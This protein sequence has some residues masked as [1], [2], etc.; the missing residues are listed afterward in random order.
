MLKQLVPLA[1]ILA[2][3]VA[4]G[5]P[6]QTRP[7]APQAQARPAAPADPLAAAPRITVAEAKKAVDAGKALLVDVRSAQ[8]F[9]MEHAKGAVNIPVS[10]VST[11]AGELPRDKQ[12]I[13]YCT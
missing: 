1:V 4:V 12:L 6:L 9:Q 2:A 13:T 8:A 3:G 10:E 11:R 7:A 5:S